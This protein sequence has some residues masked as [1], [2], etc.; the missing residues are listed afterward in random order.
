MVTAA[1]LALTL[2]NARRG[3]PA[4]PATA[5][6]AVMTGCGLEY[7]ASVWNGQWRA[8]GSLE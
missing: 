2:Y 8:D 7:L 5:F 4:L 6:Y 1:M 3:L